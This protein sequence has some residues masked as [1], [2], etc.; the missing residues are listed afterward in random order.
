MAKICSTTMEPV[1]SAA[2]SGPSTVTTGISALRSAWWTITRRSLTPL[3]R[4]VRT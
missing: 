1:T 3:A 4:A 2:N